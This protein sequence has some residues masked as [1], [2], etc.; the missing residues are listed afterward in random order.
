MPPWER[1]RV[2]LIFAGD[3]LAAIVGYAVC[4]GYED[5]SFQWA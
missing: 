3:Q 1:D 4:E 2:P 5:L